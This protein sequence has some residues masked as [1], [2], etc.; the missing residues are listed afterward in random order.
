MNTMGGSPWVPSEGITRH[1]GSS[2]PANLDFFVNPPP[3][4]GRVIS[5]DSSLTRSKQPM[6]IAKRVAISLCVGL[7]IAFVLWLLIIRLFIQDFLVLSTLI[8]IGLVVLGTRV[9]YPYTGFTHWCSYVGDEGVV[10]FRINGLRSGTSEPNLLRFKDTTNLFTRLTTTY[11]ASTPR[12][13]YSYEWTKVSDEPYS[14][15]GSYISKTRL[16]KDGDPWY[17]ANAAEAAWTQ[18]LLQATNEQFARLGHVEFP[19]YQGDLQAVRLGSDFL[20]FV[21]KDGTTQQAA[22]TKMKSVKLSEGMFQFTHKDAR[23]WS[24]RGKYSFYYGNI[25]NAKL[26]LLCLKQLTNISW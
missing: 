13:D 7:G 2:I 3:E 24:G 18:Y 1:S 25:P 5:A 12:T 22:V 11:S 15:I 17:F 21:L 6:P 4:I 8:L 9:T 10:E 23:W 19:V 14:L 16:P 26:F 20:E